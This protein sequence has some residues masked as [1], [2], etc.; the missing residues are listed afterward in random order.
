ME[1]QAPLPALAS[2]TLPSRWLRPSSPVVVTVGVLVA[3]FLL[4]NH[5]PLWHTDIWGHLRFGQW[6]VEHGR[7]PDREP[8]LPDLAGSRQL[9][10]PTAWLSQWLLYR[11]YQAG[12]GLT[13]AAES[14][15]ASPGGVEALRALHAGLV[16]LRCS[17]L[18]LAMRL[19]SGSGVVAVAGLLVML[20][21]S[22]ANI[23]VLRPQVFGEAC[24]AGMLLLLSLPRLSWSA[25]ALAVGLFVLWA[26]LHGSFLVGLGLWLGYLGGQMLL[27]YRQAGVYWRAYFDHARF[28]ELFRVF[29][30]SCLAICLLTPSGYA[31]FGHVLAVGQHPNIADMDEWK[32]LSWASPWGIAF[33]ASLWVI[34]ATLLLGFVLPPTPLTDAAG[35]LL[36]KGVIPL[37][38]LIMLGLVGSQTWLHQRMMPWWVQLVPWICVPAWGR[39]LR[40]LRPTPAPTE[41]SATAEMESVR[42]TAAVRPVLLVLVLV[43]LGLVWSGLWNWLVQGQ[44]RPLEQALHP[45]T[46]LALARWVRAPKQAL[47]AADAPPWLRCLAELSDYPGPVFA[48]E[49]QGEFLL[50]AARDG[51]RQPLVYTHVHLFTPAHWQAVMTVKRGGP[52]WEQILEHWGCRLLVVE[53]DLHAELC[54]QLRSGRAGWRV[55]LDEAAE[56]KKSDPKARLLIA[57]RPASQP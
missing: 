51:Q 28:R 21:L 26:N 37:G 32:A 19:V 25:Q 56:G 10:P 20:G 41:V 15:V 1:R 48:S 54:Q 12:A 34:L 22:Y 17:L 43:W 52:G 45:G 47:A 23:A 27:I 9:N 36:P 18:F 3:V 50:W 40:W 39:L 5:S 4:I 30:L 11:S 35:R 49:T 46:P 13:P 38:Q 2:T 29:Y 42:L 24:C 31:L 16:V 53:A 7:W 14:E 44:A 57:L 6:H 33:F 8:F 55:A